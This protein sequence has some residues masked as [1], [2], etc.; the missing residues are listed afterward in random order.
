MISTNVDQCRIWL[1]SITFRFSDLREALGY[2]TDGG[3]RLYEADCRIALAWAHRA[4]HEPAAA[5]QEAVRAQ[6]I[7]QETSYYWGQPFAAALL[8]TL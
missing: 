2:A 5:R 6:T 7:A 8:D 3:Y 4:A 1:L